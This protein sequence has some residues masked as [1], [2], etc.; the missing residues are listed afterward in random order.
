MMTQTDKPHVRSGTGPTNYIFLKND[1]VVG[2]LE[3][4][5]CVCA[6]K[7]GSVKFPGSEM[8]MPW[9]AAQLQGFLDR[10]VCSRIL[11]ARIKHGR[12]IAN[13]N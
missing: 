5:C 4:D 2:R 7:E 6:W 12:E 9:T 11:N 8:V 10:E 3:A 1:F 13:R